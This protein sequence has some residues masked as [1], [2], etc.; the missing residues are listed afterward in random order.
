MAYRRMNV[1]E[2]KGKLVTVRTELMTNVLNASALISAM[3]MDL[4]EMVKPVVPTF[5]LSQGI[6]DP[7]AIDDHTFDDGPIEIEVVAIH[8]VR[9]NA[10]DWEF[11]G[12]EPIMNDYVHDKF[13]QHMSQNHSWEDDA[14]FIPDEY[15]LKVL[16]GRD[17]E[18]NVIRAV[19]NG[20]II[21]T[22]LEE[23]D[24]QRIFGNWKAFY[25]K[26]PEQIDFMTERT[27][28]DS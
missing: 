18:P 22:G 6:I 3:I 26:E 11:R 21:I 23:D 27:G 15:L 2:L 20:N 16:I 12:V 5:A 4:D 19:L 7:D 17:P 28:M 13:Q 25:E 10:A 14:E 8:Q 1:D 9:I 24:V